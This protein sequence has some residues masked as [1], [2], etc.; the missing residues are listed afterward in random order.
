MLIFILSSYNLNWF[1]F[2]HR[3]CT[4]ERNYLMTNMEKPSRDRINLSELYEIQDWSKKFRVNT[5]DLTRAVTEAWNN[6]MDFELYW[7]KRKR[8]E[9]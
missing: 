6:A 8:K 9:I 3:N 1:D 5:K 7:K 2:R 4:K